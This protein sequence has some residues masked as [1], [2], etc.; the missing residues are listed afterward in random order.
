[1]LAFARTLMRQACQL[2]LLT[3]FFKRI[4]SP[5]QVNVC[6][7]SYAEAVAL[8]WSTR[9]A[10]ETCCYPECRIALTCFLTRARLP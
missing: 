2:T 9:I 3:D 7:L 5:M 4:F 6:T 10:Y 1:M 8:W